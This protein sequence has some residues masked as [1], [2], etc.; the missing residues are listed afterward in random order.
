MASAIFHVFGSLPGPDDDG[1][2]VQAVDLLEADG[3]RHERVAALRQHAAREVDIALDEP[4]DQRGPRQL[5][6]HIC[7]GQG[8]IPAWRA[9][10]R[11]LRRCTT[12]R[13]CSAHWCP[14]ADEGHIV[15]PAPTPCT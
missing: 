14:L 5:G 12:L 11:T 1:V 7:D 4:G 9:L 13:C 8:C 10:G 3:F 6:T 2:V 15:P